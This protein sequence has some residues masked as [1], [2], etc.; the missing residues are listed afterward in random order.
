MTVP[1]PWAE[2]FT[3]YRKNSDVLT[4]EQAKPIA[5][6]MTAAEW[7][8]VNTERARWQGVREKSAI[9]RASLAIVTVLE[10]FNG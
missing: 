3:L 7:E 6:K 8:W 9:A 10:M 5:E 4:P 2:A 1:A